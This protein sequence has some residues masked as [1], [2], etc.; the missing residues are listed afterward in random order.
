MS[1]GADLVRDLVLR[2]FS[3]PEDVFVW[4]NGFIEW[5]RAGDV[6][7]LRAQTS[8]PPQPPT[9]QVPTWRVKW[10][11]IPIPFLTVAVGSQVGRKVMAWNSAQ[12]SKARRERQ[13]MRG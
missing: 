10:W 7:E 9:G 4:R 1:Q 5:L 11:W 12:R 2:R 13:A 6:P 3:E 8:K